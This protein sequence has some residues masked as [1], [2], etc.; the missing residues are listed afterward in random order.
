MGQ[1]PAMQ[2]YTIHADEVLAFRRIKQREI[3][4][5]ATPAAVWLKGDDARF[6]GSRKLAVVLARKDANKPDHDVIQA[7]SGKHVNELQKRRCTTT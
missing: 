1:V 4:N 6:V 3:S 2:F 5:S 7:R